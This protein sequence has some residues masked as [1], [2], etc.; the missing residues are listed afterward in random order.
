MGMFDDV[1]YEA[2]CPVCGDPLTGWQSKDGP[3]VLDRLTPVE[4]ANVSG[5]VGRH[6]RNA[7]FYTSCA[8][9]DAWVDITIT[10]LATPEAL[11]TT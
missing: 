7:R 4:L 2:P 1:K 8:K 3:C 5:D 6:G 9:C 11:E 10:T